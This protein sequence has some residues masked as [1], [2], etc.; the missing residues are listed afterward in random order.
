MNDK[1]SAIRQK[2]EQVGKHIIKPT[3]EVELFK[4]QLHSSKIVS[5]AVKEIQQ[6][7]QHPPH[8]QMTLFSFMPTSMTRT[9]PFFPMSRQQMKKR[10]PGPDEILTF[11]SAWGEVSFKG[12]RLSV[13]DESILLNLLHLS[14]KYGSSKFLTTQYEIC[15]LMGV[16]PGKGPYNAIWNSIDRMS[17]TNIKLGTYSGTGKNR[18]LVPRMTGSIISFA[19]RDEKTDKLKIVL[20]DYFIQAYADGLFTNIDNKFRAALSGDITKSLYRF[21]QSQRPLYKT[22]KYSVSLFKLCSAINLTNSETHRLRS[23]IRAGLKELKTK[24]YFYRYQLDK[25]D[26]VTVW[27]K[28]KQISK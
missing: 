7:L 6:E 26:M 4:H 24:G 8:E 2:M 17:E 25:I 3:N 1:K 16:K 13:Y 14:D 15:R 22:G 27:Q 12:Q 9:S 21:F 10:T 20:N 11:P 19:G 18:K 23:R 5:D 28:Q